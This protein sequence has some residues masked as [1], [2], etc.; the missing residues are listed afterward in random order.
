ML[1]SLSE[2][3]QRSDGTAG[4]GRADHFDAHT[5]TGQAD[6][7]GQGPRLAGHLRSRTRRRRRRGRRAAQL[8]RRRFGPEILQKQVL[9]FIDFLH[10]QLLRRLRGR[11]HP[12]LEA[13]LFSV[14]FNAKNEKN[15]D[16]DS[17]PTAT[18][19]PPV[20][21]GSDPFTLPVSPVGKAPDRSRGRG[22]GRGRGAKSAT[23]TADA[24]PDAEG[25]TSSRRKSGYRRI[26]LASKSYIILLLS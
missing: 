26:C 8:V 18:P 5:G 14:I 11:C 21:A 25:Q 24:E 1:F 6:A 2:P 7:R 4:T 9:F 13:L 15:N 3:F 17:P 12:T 16:R 23:P 22:R 19:P 20:F 10:Q